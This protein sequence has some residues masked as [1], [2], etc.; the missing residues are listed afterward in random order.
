M[1]PKCPLCGFRVGDRVKMISGFARM[2]GKPAGYVYGRVDDWKAGRCGHI[3]SWDSVSAATPLPNG[4]VE[5]D[6]KGQAGIVGHKPTPE[7]E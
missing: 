5:L 7:A 3:A 6:P 1:P 4:N 2:D